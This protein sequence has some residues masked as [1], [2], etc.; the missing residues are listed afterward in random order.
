[1]KVKELIRE[2]SQCDFDAEVQFFDTFWA[3]EGWG[4]H[5]HEDRWN[6]IGEVYEDETGVYLTKEW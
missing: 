2:L 5:A 1:M 3:S 6:N 4:E